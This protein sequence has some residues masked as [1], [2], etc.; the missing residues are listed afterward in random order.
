[1]GEHQPAVA[2]DLRSGDDV[3]TKVVFIAASSYSGSTLLGLLLGTD[4]KAVYLGEPNQ[5]R[6]HR[7]PARRDVVG[8]RVCACGEPFEICSFWSTVLVRY[9]AE[10]RLDMDPGFSLSNL[11]LLI[12]SLNPFA[13]RR[14]PRGRTPYAHLLEAAFRVAS[15]T[16]P[17]L[18]FVVDSSKS[19]ESLDA[20]V[21]TAGIDVAVI[22]LVRDCRGVANSYKARGHSTL[23][24]IAAWALYN[25]ALVLHARRERLPLLTVGYAALC[26]C[27]QREM[28]RLNRLLGTHLTADGITESVRRASY[29]MLGGNENVRMAIGEFPGL[30]Y[31][32]HRDRLGGLERLAAVSV[33][34]LVGGLLRWIS[35]DPPAT[36]LSSG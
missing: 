15:R 14:K 20:V 10:D 24:A 35:P 31:R 7:D 36:P 19:I 13:G 17:C 1:M 34:K 33:D 28:D 11:R 12:R 2:D 21:Q 16:H 6:R 9:Q 5:F 22:H 8:F 27:P 32:G 3:R 18:E 23:Y 25:I 29:H 26:G 4:P 30:G